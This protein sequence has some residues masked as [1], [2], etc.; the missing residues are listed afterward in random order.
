MGGG[1][2]AIDTSKYDAEVE[3]LKKP[4]EKKGASEDD[5]IALSHAY[6]DRANALTKAKQYRAALGDY[7]RTLKYD[8]QNDEALQMAGTIISIL[9]QMGRDIPQEGAEPT[10]L[11]FK[12]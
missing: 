10:P 2:Q 5:R 11:P 12:Q 1:G 6:F 7:R 4:A 8:P 9:R 3:R